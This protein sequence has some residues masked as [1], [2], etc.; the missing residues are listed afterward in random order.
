MA[1]HLSALLFVG[2]SSG[3]TGIGLHRHDSRQKGLMSVRLVAQF[4][5][6]TTVPLQSTAALL[7]PA[8]QAVTDVV[9]SVQGKVI[10]PEP[11]VLQPELATPANPPEDA[12]ND[13]DSQPAAPEVDE[14]QLLEIDSPPA[15]YFKAWELSAQ[16]LVLSDSSAD[17]V[18]ELSESAPEPLIAH[19]LINEDGTIDQIVLEPTSLSDE[20][21]QFVIEAFSKTRFSP[22]KQGDKP[23]KTDLMIEIRLDAVPTM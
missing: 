20:A 11:K 22:G 17:Q 2:I 23:V 18:R 10:D 21:Q 8:G 9:A 6:A 4:S 16:P 5:T 12:S 7:S 15:Y 14:P 19:L 1:L 3:N 13:V